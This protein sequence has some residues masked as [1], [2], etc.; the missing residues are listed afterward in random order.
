MSK[1]KY[2]WEELTDQDFDQLQSYAK[3]AVIVT[4]KVVRSAITHMLDAGC[5]VPGIRLISQD[6]DDAPAKPD[7]KHSRKQH[8]L[9]GAN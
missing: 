1:T 4:R 7:P 8:E 6:H 3:N 9:P 2:Q 5:D